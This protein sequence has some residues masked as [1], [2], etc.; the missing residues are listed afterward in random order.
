MPDATSFVLATLPP[1]PA[2]VLEVGCGEG[3]LAR[4]LDAAGYH[5]LAVD[6]RAP[7]G[8]LFRRIG[9]EDLPEVEPFEAVVARYALHHVASLDAALDRIAGLLRPGGRLVIEEFGWDRVD[10][11]TAGWYARYG[12]GQSAD[13]ALRDWRA[14]H[15]G[16]HTYAS[17]RP[18]LDRRYV[19]QVF[20]WR[21]YLYTC[22]DRDDLESVESEA[23]RGDE[24][25]AV[26]FRY[27]GL[28][29]DD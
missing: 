5:V 13:A 12:S 14:E 6:P 19:E 3:E 24:I 1:P 2:R 15:D 29:G 22:L 25:N 9:V 21:P 27:V 28:V 7:E 23:I 16:L 20:E 4:E 8:P 26:G 10:R 17:M 18:A 11:S